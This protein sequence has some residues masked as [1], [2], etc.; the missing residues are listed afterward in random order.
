MMAD[1]RETGNLICIPRR[2]VRQSR[3]CVTL[4]WLVGGMRLVV[5]ADKI[6]GLVERGRN[7]AAT[8]RNEVRLVPK[9]VEK[10]E[11]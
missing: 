2:R 10:K 7:V 6:S 1:I 9:F 5:S 8:W 11:F 4:R 3:P